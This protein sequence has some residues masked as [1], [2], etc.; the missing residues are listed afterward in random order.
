[1]FQMDIKMTVTTNTTSPIEQLRLQLK[2]S[3]LLD[4]DDYA[5]V[6]QSTGEFNSTFLGV[7]LNTAFQPIY[8]I[9][10]GDLIGHEALLRP[11]LGGEL[12]STPEFAFTYAEQ[13][14]KLIQFDRVA[15][16]LHVL[17]FKQIYAENGLLFLNV[18]PK[19]LVSVNTHGKVF[20]RIL[21]ANSVPT[22]RVVIEI[23]ES[24]IEQDKQLSEAIDN[25]RDRAYRIAIDGFGG[26]KSHI[27]RLWKLSPDFV[28]LDLSIIQ[29]AEGNPRVQRILPGLINLIQESGA[30][31]VVTG[32]E[33]Q[34][35][36][37]IAIESGAL[38][39]QGYFL[40]KPVTAK[41]LQP[42]SALNKLTQIN[43]AS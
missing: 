31:A 9:A 15:R 29:Q 38:F 40:A 20:E 27:D 37:D 35:Q 33:S 6:E 18:H 4:L 25:Y 24:E 36:L 42:S 1:M 41:A 26:K 34:T 21:H 22:H 39:V 12:T 3:L 5:L 13:T 16:T 17:N 2:E 23:K 28:K 11:S 19:L 14:G 10:A 8:D 7:Q 30:K 43:K 32:I